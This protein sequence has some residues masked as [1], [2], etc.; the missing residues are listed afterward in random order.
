MRRLPTPSSFFRPRRDHSHVEYVNLYARGLLAHYLFIDRAGLFVG[1]ESFRFRA[2]CVR[3]PYPISNVIN[4]Q[5]ETL[6]QEV[7]SE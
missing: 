2:G 1:D 5:K 7:T 3:C 4:K 6:S